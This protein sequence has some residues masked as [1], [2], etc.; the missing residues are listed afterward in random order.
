MALNE[1][2]LH[3]IAGKDVHSDKEAAHF[4]S[5]SHLRL[6]HWDDIGMNLFQLLAL[7]FFDFDR[8]MMLLLVCF[9]WLK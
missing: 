4:L 6:P 1:C 7:I 8:Q 2:P 3:Y 5:P 9:V